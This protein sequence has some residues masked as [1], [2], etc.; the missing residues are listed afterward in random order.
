DAREMLRKLDDKIMVNYSF[1]I[2]KCTKTNND[3]VLVKRPNKETTF[4]FM[5][6]ATKKSRPNLCLTD[7]LHQEDWIG[8]L[9]VWVCGIDKRA[10]MLRLANDDYGSIMMQALGDR[11]AEAT[12][13][14][15]HERVRKSWWGYSKDEN[16]TN[17]DLIKERY[18]GIRPAPGYPACPDHTQ[19]IKI[20]NWLEISDTI[21]LTEGLTMSPKSAICGW[22]FAS[23]ESKYFGVGKI[24]D[25]YVEDLKERNPYLKKYK[26][27]ITGVS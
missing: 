23:A 7:F 13:E 21:E 10:D 8:S 15:L 27:H 6:Q 4:N 11:L 17:T 2:D 16:L 18:L 20:L 24:P 25:E 26:N 9:A 19:K 1:A 14:W 22:Y 5:R 3:D 12:A